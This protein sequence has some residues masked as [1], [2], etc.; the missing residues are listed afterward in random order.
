M[1]AYSNKHAEF[2]LHRAVPVVGVRRLLLFHRMRVRETHKQSGILK[3]FENI[4]SAARHENRPASP[5]DDD[6]L[7]WLDLSEL[8][9][10]RTTGCERRSIRIHLGD[11]G[12]EGCSCS[13]GSQCSSCEVE[14][15][16]PGFW[17]GN[18]G[19]SGIDC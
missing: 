10:N 12:N 15:I 3:R 7:S 16:T 13:H 8:E 14:K 11:Q 18:F 19:I 6:L 2:G 17:P 5:V 1:G 4:R 9:F